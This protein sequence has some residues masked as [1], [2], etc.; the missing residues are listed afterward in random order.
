[1]NDKAT[2][3]ILQHRFLSDAFANL[4]ESNEALVLEEL[5]NLILAGELEMNRPFAELIGVNYTRLKWFI[6]CRRHRL[7]SPPIRCHWEM[8][9]STQSELDYV[10]ALLSHPE[11]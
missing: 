3:P 2:I 10:R 1:M 8:K 11:I 9:K 5:A 6:Y 4:L 7:P